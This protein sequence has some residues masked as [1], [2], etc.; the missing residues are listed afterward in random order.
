L[1]FGNKKLW[2][3]FG[4]AGGVE[5]MLP[6]GTHE[7]MERDYGRRTNGIAVD[8]SNEGL[9]RSGF[10]RLPVSAAGARPSCQS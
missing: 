6:M 7:E 5:E 4:R 2:I 1:D 8:E 3:V 10:A 9:L